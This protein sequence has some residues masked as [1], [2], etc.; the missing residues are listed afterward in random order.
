MFRQTGIGNH[1]KIRCLQQFFMYAELI[2]TISIENANTISNVFL[3]NPYLP[4]QS[5]SESHRIETSSRQQYHKKSD[6]TSGEFF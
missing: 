5:R 1:Y 3:R 6:D 2:N 4:L